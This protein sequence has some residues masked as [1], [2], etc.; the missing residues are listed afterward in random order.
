MKKVS[1]N[2]LIAGMFSQNFK[3]TVKAFIANDGAFNFMNAIKGTP[4]YWKRF[5]LEVLA[6]VRQL[7]VPTFFLTL[8]CADLRWFELPFILSKLYNLNLT[9]DEI[10]DMNYDDRCRYLNMNPVFVARHFQYRVEAFFKEIVLN[11]SFARENE[12]SCNKCRISS[13]R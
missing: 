6:M 5:L 9:D 8:S 1:G 4:A 2:N 7:G 11:G 10:R 3:E 13:T 12:V